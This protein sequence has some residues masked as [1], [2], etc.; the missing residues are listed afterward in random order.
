M[1]P[2]LPFDGGRVLAALDRRI[3]F[4]GFLALLGFQVW[5]WL[6]GSFPLALDNRLAC[7]QSTWVTSYGPKNAASEP[8]TIYD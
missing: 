7:R 1:I 3:W 4:L 8:T 6:S 2:T 5:Q